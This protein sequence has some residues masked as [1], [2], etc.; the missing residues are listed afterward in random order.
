MADPSSTPAQVAPPAQTFTFAA[1][2]ETALARSTTHTRAFSGP[3][4]ASGTPVVPANGGPRANPGDKTGQDAEAVLPGWL[5]HARSAVPLEAQPPVWHGFVMAQVLHPQKEG[6]SLPVSPVLAGD[7]GGVF[8]AQSAAG[9]EHVPEMI[10]P[11][12][13]EEEVY[14]SYLI[15]GRSSLPCYPQ[16]EWE[17]RRRYRDFAFLHDGLARD[18]PACVVPPLPDK[19][20]IEYLAGDRFSPDFIHRRTADLNIFLE[21]VCRHPLLMRTPLLCSFLSSN[22]WV[23]LPASPPPPPPAS[24][25]QTDRTTGCRYALAHGCLLSGHQF[26]RHRRCDNGPWSSGQLVG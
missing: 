21:R 5:D 8:L 20:R 11:E 14:V 9:Q 24:R 7:D 23:R 10:L 6:V 3:S 13:E 1:A 15:R 19:H 16:K 2:G 4:S 12:D 17:V 26:V 22:E 25:L 18:F